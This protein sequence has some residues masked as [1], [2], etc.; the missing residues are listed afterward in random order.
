[1]DYQQAAEKA[2]TLASKHTAP[3]VRSSAGLCLQDAMA[4]MARGKPLAAYIR[5]MDSLRYSVGVCAKD[6][7]E[8]SSASGVLGVCP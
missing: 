2:I 8:A 6:Y 4:C 5:A 7:S 3:D 1:M